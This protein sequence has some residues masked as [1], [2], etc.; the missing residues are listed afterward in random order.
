MRRLAIA[1]A[2]VACAA[3]ERPVAQP[4][5]PPIVTGV[6]TSVI[7]TM[8][9]RSISGE[10]RWS[11]AQRDSAM[12]VL[13]T[14]RAKWITFRPRTYEYREHG[15]CFCYSMWAGPRLLV[16]RD[17]RLVTATD[18]SR[19]RVDSAYTKALRGKVAGIDALFAEMAEGIRDTTIAQVRVSYDAAHGYPVSVTYDRSI[20]GSDDEY[21]VDVSHVRAIPLASPG[22][23]DAADPTG[24]RGHE[25]DGCRSG[26]VLV[27]VGG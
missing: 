20:M 8:V 5:A 6:R 12:A 25:A 18:T 7:D 17:E 3:R 27:R 19:R 24:I 16:I 4:S 14:N 15:W 26:G 10:Y 11:T 21:H 13:A 1:L 22:T 2:L 9:L 23:G